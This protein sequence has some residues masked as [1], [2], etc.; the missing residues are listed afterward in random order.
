MVKGHGS[1]FKFNPSILGKVGVSLQMARMPL[2][3]PSL[4]SPGCTLHVP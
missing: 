1:G 3:P 4:G 2:G